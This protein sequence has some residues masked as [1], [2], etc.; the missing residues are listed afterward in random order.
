MIM[1]LTMMANVLQ[2][3]TIEKYALFEQF[4][5]HQCHKKQMEQSMKEVERASHQSTMISMD[6]NLAKELIAVSLLQIF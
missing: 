6:E 4:F 2:S 5:L 3:T 1:N